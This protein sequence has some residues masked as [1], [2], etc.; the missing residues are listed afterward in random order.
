[1]DRFGHLDTRITLDKKQIR[2]RES[3]LHVHLLSSIALASRYTRYAFTVI[4]RIV[5][6]QSVYNANILC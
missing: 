4:S 2:E 6:K 5:E 1:M 3:M